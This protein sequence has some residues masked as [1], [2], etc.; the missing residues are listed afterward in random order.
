MIKMEDVKA[1]QWCETSGVE[2]PP[3]SDTFC[4]RDSG[5][6]RRIASRGK[7]PLN[8]GNSLVSPPNE[9]DE[10]FVAACPVERA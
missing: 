9:L 8:S 2:N 10:A 3:T 7:V 5:A 6:V 4:Q 1:N